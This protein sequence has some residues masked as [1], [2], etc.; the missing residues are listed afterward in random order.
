MIQIEDAVV[1]TDTYQESE[2]FDDSFVE[3]YE[4]GHSLMVIGHMSQRIQDMKVSHRSK[5]PNALLIQL[6]D[7]YLQ[8]NRLEMRRM[9]EWKE[10][11]LLGKHQERDIDQKG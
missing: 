9:L 8:Q 3:V 2:A 11:N 7:Q 1:S 4:T 10:L 5:I 6:K